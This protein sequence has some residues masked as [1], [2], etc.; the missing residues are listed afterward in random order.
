MEGLQIVSLITDASL[1][2]L[3]M[4]FAVKMTRRTSV[5]SPEINTAEI[6]KSVRGI[7]QDAEEAGRELSRDLQKR[8]RS[9]E[10]LLFDLEAVETRAHRATSEAQVK[11][12]S[13]SQIAKEAE[14]RTASVERRT[15][16]TTARAPAVKQEMYIEVIPEAEPEATEIQEEP[17][18]YQNQTSENV[19]IFGEPI[20]SVES[21]SK[22]PPLS[23][24]IEIERDT[25]RSH[26]P[27]RSSDKET[28][29]RIQQ[30]YEQAK[31]LL[32]AGKNVAEV[33]AATRLPAAAVRRI[34]QTI[35]VESPQ[36]VK[37]ARQ[38]RDPRLGALSG[39]TRSSE[40]I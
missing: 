11:I 37:Q 25:N 17:S 36:Q 1:T 29:L 26:K 4:A 20:P 40:V 27:A 23:E 35:F 34:E 39:M 28:R 38:S 18:R 13:L 30:I 5:S 6:E 8:Q 16:N 33:S 2:L 12:D 22:N 32:A 7:I 9:L 15:E 24:R 10:Q 19:N 21:D 3:V 14:T 31:E